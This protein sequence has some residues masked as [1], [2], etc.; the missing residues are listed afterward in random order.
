MA[1][2][3]LTRLQLEDLVRETLGEFIN[4]EVFDDQAFHVAVNYAIREACRM[5]ELVRST[6]TVSAVNGLA[7]ISGHAQLNRNLWI[8]RVSI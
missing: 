5:R 6:A 1:H 2:D 8:E 4:P 7:D 3:R